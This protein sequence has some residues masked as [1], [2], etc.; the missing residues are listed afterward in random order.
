MSSSVTPTHGAEPTPFRAGE[1][2]SRLPTAALDINALATPAFLSVAL[3]TNL[4][5]PFRVAL[6]VLAPVAVPVAVDRARALDPDALTVPDQRLVPTC[7]AAGIGLAVTPWNQ[8]PIDAVA[9]VTGGTSVRLEAGEQRPVLPPQALL[10]PSEA[11]DG[12]CDAAVLLRAGLGAEFPR[13]AAGT[14]HALVAPD[15]AREL[16]VFGSALALITLK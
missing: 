11:V 8:V 12:V 3:P 16:H 15:E 13:L 2:L 7:G 1:P 10:F 4:E 9:A 5:D 14:G 6:A